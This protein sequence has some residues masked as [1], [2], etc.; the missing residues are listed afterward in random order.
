MTVISPFHRTLDEA[1]NSNTDNAPAK[2]QA[3]RGGKGTSVSNPYL[4][5]N[6]AGKLGSLQSFSQVTVT[7]AS[8][9]FDRNTVGLNGSVSLANQLIM[10]LGNSSLGIAA[11]LYQNQYKNG[12]ETYLDVDKKGN[13]VAQDRE[14]IG[15]YAVPFYEYAFNDKYNFRT[16]FNWFNF[17]NSRADDKLRQIVPQQSM[18]VGISVTRDVFLY[19]NI[20][21]IPQDIRADRTNVALSANINIF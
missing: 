10:E 7:Y 8:E 13:L 2:I 15:V 11:A 3:K 12:N 17:S 5:F 19:P 16:V 4:E 6:H 14:D 20:Q 1:T 21:F 9:D 18:G